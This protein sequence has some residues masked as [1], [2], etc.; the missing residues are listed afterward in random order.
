MPAEPGFV[1]SRLAAPNIGSHRRFAMPGE[2]GRLLTWN[3]ARRTRWRADA[4]R[5]PGRMA[6][7]MAAVKRQAAVDQRVK[8]PS[9]GS[10]APIDAGF[11]ATATCTSSVTASS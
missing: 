4:H 2:P 7:C 9:E 8:A 5:H 11:Q 1:V 6:P 3:P 10:P